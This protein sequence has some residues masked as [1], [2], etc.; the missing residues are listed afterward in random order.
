MYE[1]ARVPVEWA[2]VLYFNLNNTLFLALNSYSIKCGFDIPLRQT[3][4]L[5]STDHSAGTL[6]HGTRGRPVHFVGCGEHSEG[7]PDVPAFLYCQ[8]VKGFVV[9]STGEMGIHAF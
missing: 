7:V 5:G 2:T 9:D 3:Q 4:I 1:T 6:V 8:I